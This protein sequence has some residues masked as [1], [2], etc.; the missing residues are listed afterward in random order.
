M[1]CPVGKPSTPCF[2]FAPEREFRRCADDH[3]HSSR[4]G[5]GKDLL[6]VWLR[7]KLHHHRDLLGD[8]IACCQQVPPAQ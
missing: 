4:A 5:I 7:Q 3:G 1:G 6:V 8:V 2:R